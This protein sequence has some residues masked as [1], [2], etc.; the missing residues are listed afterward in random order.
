MP[1]VGN[2]ISVCICTFKRPALLAGL[3]EKLLEQKTDG[4][5]TYSIVVADNDAGQS[6]KA[7]VTSFEHKSSIPISYHHE[8]EQNIALARNTA[9]K[10]A[11]GDLAA[12]IDDDEF[13]SD[14]WLLTML[15]A[16]H[17]HNA[18]GILGAV[19]PFFEGVPPEWL[20]N[21]RF[22]EYAVFPTGTVL[23]WTQGRTGNFLFRLKAVKDRNAAFDPRFG[24]GAEDQD[25]FRRMIEK[26]CIFK[27]CGEAVVHEYVPPVRWKRTFLLRRALLRGKVALHHP[28]SKA[29]SIVKSLLAVPAYT[30]LLPFL[31]VVRHDIFMRFLIK[32]FDHI[33]KLIAACGIDIVRQKYVT[34]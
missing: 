8:P 25:F 16:L 14:D 18:D 32:D 31:L 30:A 15:R 5:F 29:K 17:E 21:G 7:V 23:K 33:G 10:N 1:Q 27:Y 13:P 4:L 3:L 24:S 19:R 26:G 34:E 28:T 12:F 9:L 11:H 6:A 22:W 20:R 2:H